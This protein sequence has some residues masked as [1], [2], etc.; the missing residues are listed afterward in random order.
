M[1]LRML[2]ILLQINVSLL[3]ILV[4]SC[5][6]LCSFVSVYE[7]NERTQMNMNELSS[8]N[9]QTWTQ[10]FVVLY[11]REP[12]VCPIKALRTNEQEQCRVRL[13]YSPRNE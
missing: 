6:N 8:L 9:G 4:Y 5:I 7:I 10:N 11:V 3:V 13:V 2:A 12:S 1:R